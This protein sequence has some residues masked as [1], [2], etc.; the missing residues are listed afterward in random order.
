MQCYYNPE[1]KGCPTQ[2]TARDE[3]RAL[4]LNLFNLRYLRRKSLVSTSNDKGHEG[5]HL[6]LISRIFVGEMP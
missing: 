3:D 4:P 5:L 6:F 1:D 2:Q